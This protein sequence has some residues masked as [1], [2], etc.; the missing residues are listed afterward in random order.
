MTHEQRELEHDRAL[1]KTKRNTARYFT[2]T[3]HVAWVFLV[4]TLLWGVFGYLRM[5]KAKDPVVEVRVAAA[6]C[7]WGAHHA[8]MD[9]RR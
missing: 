5:P 8:T 2:E 6:V 3:R 4:F 1:V 9:A 7:P